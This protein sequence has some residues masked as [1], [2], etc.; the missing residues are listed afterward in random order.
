MAALRGGH[1]EEISTLCTL[2]L[3]GRIKCG[4]DNKG[5]AGLSFFYNDLRAA[6]QQP[7]IQDSNTSNKKPASRTAAQ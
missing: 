3:D 7:S 2:K 5:L 4:H 6:E 1:P